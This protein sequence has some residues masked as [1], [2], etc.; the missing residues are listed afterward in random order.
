[1]LDKRLTKNL[2]PALSRGRFYSD[3]CYLDQER[4]S[5]GNA[6]LHY[7]HRLTCINRKG[8]WV[9]CI[10]FRSYALQIVVARFIGR[11]FRNQG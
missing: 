5:V 4:V 9:K 11:L 3:S 2:P 7:L 10:L 6:D 8:R 1:M